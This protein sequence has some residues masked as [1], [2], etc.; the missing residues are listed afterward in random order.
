VILESCAAHAR[1]SRIDSTLVVAF[2]AGRGGKAIPLCIIENVPQ[3]TAP[4]PVALSMY[5]SN[6]RPV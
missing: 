3:S 5:W 2:D 6:V 1:D 4:A